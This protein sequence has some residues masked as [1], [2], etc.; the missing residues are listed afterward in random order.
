MAI[1]DFLNTQ[2]PKEKLA[3]ALEVLR[4]FKTGESQ[5]EWIAVPFSAWAKLEQ[6]EEFLAHL[7][8]GAELADD[9]KAYI[10]AQQT[11]TAT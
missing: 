8:E 7:V 3:S 4:E 2:T 5:E 10:A 9:T 11:T 6:M 1:T